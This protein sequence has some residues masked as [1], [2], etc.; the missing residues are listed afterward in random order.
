MKTY[1]FRI[2]FSMTLVNRFGKNVLRIIQSSLLII[3][4]GFPPENMLSPGVGW[5]GGP[6]AAK[7]VFVTGA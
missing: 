5:K 6:P 4:T 2:Q 1:T 3:L 7:H